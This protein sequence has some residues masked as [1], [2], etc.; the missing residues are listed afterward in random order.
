MVYT[1][2]IIMFSPN[3]NCTKIAFF[4]YLT[5]R[6]TKIHL[7]E[8]NKKTMKLWIHF[9]VNYDIDSIKSV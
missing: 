2:F 7:V 9:I 8:M 4:C 1:T 5:N 3:H 6:N